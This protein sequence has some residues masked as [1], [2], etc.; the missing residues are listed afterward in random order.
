MR[1]LSYRVRKGI[2]IDLFYSICCVTG[3]QRDV[4][5][6]HCWCYGKSQID[7]LWA[8]VPLRRDLNTSHPPMEVKEKCQIISLIR[9]TSEDLAKYPKKDWAQI[10]KY[11][12]GKYPEFYQIKLKQILYNN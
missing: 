5:M 12:F 1:K 4:S 10:K 3:D 7:E 9:A 2:N 11:L 6:Q 8:I